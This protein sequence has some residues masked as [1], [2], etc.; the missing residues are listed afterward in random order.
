MTDVYVSDSVA[1]SVLG[2]GGEGSDLPPVRF[3]LI[4][5]FI[6]PYFLLISFS[7]FVACLAVPLDLLIYLPTLFFLNVFCS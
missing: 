5:L 3:V 7:C 6:I 1:D 2:E 4:L